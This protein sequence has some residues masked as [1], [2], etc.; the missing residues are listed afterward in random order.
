MPRKM[1][2]LDTYK[3]ELLSQVLAARDSAVDDHDVNNGR[4]RASWKT[5]LGQYPLPTR[6]DITL[7]YVEPVMYEAVSSLT[8]TLLN[9]FTGNEEQAVR[10]QPASFYKAFEGHDKLQKVVNETINKIFIRENNGYRVLEDAFKEACITGDAVVKTYVNQSHDEDFIE[11]DDFVSLDRLIAESG[12]WQ[13]DVPS[14]FNEDG[15]LKKTKTVQHYKGMD[16]KLVEPEGQSAMA[17]VQG[18]QM[19]I[20]GKIKVYRDDKQV[21]IELVDF[22]NFYFNTNCGSDFDKVRYCCERKQMTVGEALALGYDEDAVNAA[23][24]FNPE[25]DSALDKKELLVLDGDFT[26]QDSDAT[27]YT[28]EMERPIA[29]W[30]HYLYSS[31]PTGKTALY[32]VITTDAEL[33]SC[34][35]ISRIPY[36]KMQYE[37][38]P[39]S[40]WGRSLYDICSPLQDELSQMVRVMRRHAEHSMFGAWSVVRGQYDRKAMIGLRPGSLVEVK[41]QGDV[42]PLPLPQLSPS[43]T[44]YLERMRAMADR[45]VQAA[46]DKLVSQDAA[47]QMAAQAIGMLI[48][49]GELK[50]KVVAQTIARTGIRPLFMNLYETLRD[51]AYVIDTDEG[52]FTADKFPSVYDFVVDVNTVNDQAVQTSGL[53]Q[54]L[55]TVAQAKQAVGGILTDKNL[56]KIA[57]F[58]C[59]TFGVKGEEFFT[60]PDTQQPDPQS[61]RLQEITA[62]Q[63][64]EIQALAVEKANAEVA[65]AA[66]QIKLVET[67]IAEMVKNGEATRQREKEKSLIEFQKIEA[68]VKLTEAKVQ[69]EQSKTNLQGAA[70]GAEIQTG[71]NLSGVKL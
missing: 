26:S 49:Q 7:S 58:A 5:Y 51:E 41:D 60:D 30:E 68:D 39:G 31:L 65:S 69:A 64:A 46:S 50:D 1:K 66:A 53:L 38:V 14:P 28:D 15:T 40:P 34:V 43:V 61:M 54:V 70:V 11:V 55:N 57:D 36:V 35:P 2:K 37:T 62:S 63:Q 67:Q 47:P 17:Q 44:A 8:P 27:I 52:P 19:M 48:A 4:Y 25:D 9:V 42:Q 59:K 16:W 24:S 12:N 33:I 29:I 20:K 10:Y 56:F 22:Q 6:G 3:D 32:Q 71:R 45:I 21:M 23:T 18:P 13:F